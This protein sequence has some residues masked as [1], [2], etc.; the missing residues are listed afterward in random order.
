MATP[1]ISKGAVA[2]FSRAHLDTIICVLH[3]SAK[4][5]ETFAATMAARFKAKAYPHREADHQLAQRTLKARKAALTAALTQWRYITG[6]LYTG[7]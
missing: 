4:D 6:N 3:S 2:Q 5:T 7:L 1:T